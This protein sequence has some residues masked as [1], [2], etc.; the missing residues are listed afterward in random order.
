MLALFAE[1]TD[2]LLNRL[3]ALKGLIPLSFLQAQQGMCHVQSKWAVSARPGWDVASCLSRGVRPTA[4]PS[5]R[6]RFCF[7]SCFLRHRG[8]LRT[9]Q[10]PAR[11]C[12]QLPPAEKLGQVQVANII[13]IFCILWRCVEVNLDIFDIIKIPLAE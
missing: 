1:I 12:S 2:I 8:P 13:F 10:V 4:A 7:T 9:W 11:T 3:W 6:S 5:R